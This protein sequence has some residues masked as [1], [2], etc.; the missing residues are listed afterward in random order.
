MR[1]LPIRALILASLVLA[2]CASEAPSGP[3]TCESL[4]GTRSGILR[5]L[6]FEVAEEGVSEGFDVDDRVGPDPASACRQRDYRDAEGRTGIDNQL[7]VLVPALEMQVGEGTLQGLL[8]SAINNGQLLIAITLDG[9]DDLRNDDCV[10][11]TVQTLTGM[12][13]LG[14]DGF[15]LDGQTLDRS[16]DSPDTRY[17]GARIVDGVV[18][19][20]PF[21]FPLPVAIL[22]ARF[23]LDLH[24][25]RI[26]ARIH[27][28]GSMTGVIG[29]GID[30]EQILEITSGL[31]IPPELMDMVA[32]F[33]ALI[34][35]LAPDADGHCG[36]FS[37][38]ITFD[39]I[40][41]F[42]NP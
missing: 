11:V 37:A 1:A 19:T 8:Q 7:T 23:V 25:A 32:S 28:D 22:D 38:A 36:R 15:L 21:D 10:A 16:P 3:R 31:N 24:G 18:E 42:V 26:R 20:G 29:G 30:N 13:L 35:D 33:V 14:T 12:P 27:E 40:P 9:V 5:T 34:A 39:A 4:E 2:G 41:G 17:E 6:V